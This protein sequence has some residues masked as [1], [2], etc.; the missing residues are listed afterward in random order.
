MLINQKIKKSK[1]SANT[2]GKNVGYIS[3]TCPLK[4][5][6]MKY[7]VSQYLRSWILDNFEGLSN[8]KSNVLPSKRIRVPKIAV[9]NNKG[10]LSKVKGI[11]SNIS[12]LT[13]I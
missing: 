8:L 13:Q 9:K 6:L 4:Q 3:H 2:W 5:K 12:Y 10:E 7:L 1:S 11:I